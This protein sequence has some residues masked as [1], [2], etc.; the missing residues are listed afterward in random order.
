MRAI[1]SGLRGS[2]DMRASSNTSAATARSRASPRFPQYVQPPIP[3]AFADSPAAAAY[4]RAW[5]FFQAGDL[6]TAEREFSGVLTAAPMF[7]PAE[8]SLGYVELAR[9]DPKA[10]L[11]HF[12]RALESDNVDVPALLGRGDA[13]LALD[14]QG[15]A[16]ATLEAAVAADPSLADVRRRIEVLRFRAVEE[17]VA[18]ARQLA[19]QNRGEDAVQAYA[20]AIASSPDSAFLYREVA[21][22]ER[23]RGNTDGA[24]ADFQKA[25]ALDPSD[26]RS[27]AQVGDILDARGDLD[28]AMKAYTD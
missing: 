6:K 4:T 10:A 3:A 20:A 18:R 25:I 7:Y 2:I 8:T 21:A 5:T 14:R 23:Q 13:L 17:H 26:A 22:I 19:R 1:A 16:L 24:L 15:D 12:D 27:L 11:P 9:K 28:G